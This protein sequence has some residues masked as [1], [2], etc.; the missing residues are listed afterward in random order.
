MWEQIP[1]FIMT[2]LDPIGVVIGLVIAV[3]VLWTWYEVAFGQH[4]R[5]R[6][7]FL[8]LREHPGRRPGILILD[9]LAGKEVRASVERFRQTDAA[10]KDIPKDRVFCLTRGAS[11]TLDDLPGLHDELRSVAARA[12]AD[13]IDVLHY[14]HA[15]PACVAAVVGGE[16]AKPAV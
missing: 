14:F 4:R 8:A 10:L 12:L 3:P 2:Y 11:L 15:G 6:R 13:G 7:L 9:L 16:F 5:R 1:D